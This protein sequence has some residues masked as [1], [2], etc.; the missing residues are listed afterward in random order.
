MRPARCPKMQDRKTS[1]GIFWL[2]IVYPEKTGR[3]GGGEAWR[4][5]M[6]LPGRQILSVVKLGG[7]AEK[8]RDG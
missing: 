6:K 2:N 1:L 7:G 5:K 3:G 4:I 8:M